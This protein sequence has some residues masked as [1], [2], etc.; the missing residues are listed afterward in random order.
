M[1]TDPVCSMVVDGWF[2]MENQARG[3]SSFALIFPG[4]SALPVRFPTVVSQGL[5]I[6]IPNLVSYGISF[7]ILSDAESVTCRKDR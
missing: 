3:R 2:G 4:S 6:R 7:Y 1:A 5:Q